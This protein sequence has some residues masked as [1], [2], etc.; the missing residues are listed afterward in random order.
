VSGSGKDKK[1]C[2]WGRLHVKQSVDSALFT[3]KVV[4]SHS[5][6]LPSLADM[7]GH[8]SPWEPDLPLGDTIHSNLLHH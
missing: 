3:L 5:D 2:L 7:I 8:S 1:A 6:Y 4:H